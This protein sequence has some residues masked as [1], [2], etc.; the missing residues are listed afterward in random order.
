MR[1]VN[2]GLS[3]WTQPPSTGGHL[4]DGLTYEEQAIRIEIS[5]EFS[6]F[7]FKI[8]I[9]FFLGIQ[10]LAAGK[11]IPSSPSSDFIADT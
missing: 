6:A 2:H 3:D 5:A 7:C 11:F 4:R 9:G 8:K 1:F 10:N